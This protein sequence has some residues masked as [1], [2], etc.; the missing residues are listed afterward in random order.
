MKTIKDKFIIDIIPLT[1]IPLTRNQSF[2][3]WADSKIPAG[4]LLS[5]PF[6][7]RN[8]EGIVLGTRDDFKRFNNKQFLVKC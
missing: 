8:I 6:F 5:I 1:K 3:Y 2:S 4:S 7:R